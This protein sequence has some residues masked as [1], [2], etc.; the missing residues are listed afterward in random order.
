MAPSWWR[1]ELND[2]GLS[3]G[4]VIQ[5]LPFAISTNPPTRL[6]KTTGKGGV[7]TWVPTSQSSGASQQHF[8]FEGKEAL[9]LVVSHSCDLDK[10]AARLRVLVAPIRPITALEPEVQEKVMEQTRI[11]LMPL[12]ELPGVGDSYVDL[13]SIIA[14][15]RKLIPDAA[16]V[17]SMSDEGLE[18]LQAQLV[19]FFTRLKLP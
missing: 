7:E 14:V 4:D 12:P 6:K 17:A 9:G 15:P 8:L 2:A 5:D 1:P 11:P 10:R 16:R 13:R 3:Q 19:L 18:R